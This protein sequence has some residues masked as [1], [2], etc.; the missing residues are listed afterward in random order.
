MSVIDLLATL[1]TLNIK[2]EIISDNLK[3][4]S[5]TG[6]L[7]EE[8][9]IKIKENKDQIL[10]YL[11]SIEIFST[12]Q[13]INNFEKKD[14]YKLSSSQKRLYFMQQVDLNITSYNMPY[15]IRVEGNIEIDR[16][17]VIIRK[18]IIRHE[19]LRT[20]FAVIE[21][22]PF[23]RINKEV[24]LEIEYYKLGEGKEEQE[25]IIKNFI[26]PFNLLKAPLFRVG[27]IKIT[28]EK[29]IL[30]FDMHHII[31]DGLSQNILFSEFISLYSG[32]E[33]PPMRLQYKDYAEWQNRQQ[34]SDD[35]KK[36]GK[37]WHKEYSD[38]PPLLKLPVDFAKPSGKYFDGNTLEFKIDSEE[39]QLLTMLAVEEGT[40]IFIVLL[41][42]YTV[43]LWKL[44][45]QGEIVV[46]T[47]VAGRR[48][49]D[50]Q[51]I[52]GI[53]INM[54]PLRNFPAPEKKFKDFLAEVR[55]R[56]LEAFENQDYPY[57]DL[58]EK[59]TR[60]R[61]ISRNPLFDVVFNF[62]NRQKPKTEI[63]GLSFES[64]DY[65]NTIS[66]FD[67]SLMGTKGEDTLG[68]RIIYSTKLFAIETIEGFIRCF[69]EILSAV[70]MDKEIALKDIRI[71]LVLADTNLD[72]PE[73][74]FNFKDSL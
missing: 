38:P 64:Y 58:V 50:L 13:I 22:E 36:Q 40:T 71:N 60:T 49:A 63:F 1:N 61:D 68:F 19:I 39:T 69:K 56:T 25:K 20:F 24:E 12:T 53:F 5:P 42:V 10:N 17:A 45:G 74:N 51:P 57:E 35:I 7:T 70:L 67:M 32:E 33:L 54:L 72:I 2:L 41:A 15:I 43:M 28:T 46:G 73:I 9:K 29:H 44:T 3:I 65:E 66:K 14:F 55:E 62:E 4:L 47:P 48:H 18:L 21:G 31:T 6:V 16:L 59:V 52:M 11:R 27:I 23:Q 30:L 34:R 26:R 37:F 8:L